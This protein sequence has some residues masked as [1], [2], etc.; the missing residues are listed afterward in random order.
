MMYILSIFAAYCVLSFIV[1]SFFLRKE[2]GFLIGLKHL[3][4]IFAPITIF[5]VLLSI[6]NTRRKNNLR[7]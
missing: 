3:I 2:T 5:G 4:I 1:V 7:E 6:K